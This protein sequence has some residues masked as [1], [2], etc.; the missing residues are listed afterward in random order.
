MG[1]SFYMTQLHHL[2]CYRNVHAPR[3][4]GASVQTI[5]IKQA[6]FSPSNNRGLAFKGVR[7]DRADSKLS[8]TN[9]CRTLSIEPIWYLKKQLTFVI[10]VGESKDGFW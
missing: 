8:S 1:N 4:S 5:A 7:R 6:S 9:F 10:K 3:P 2:V